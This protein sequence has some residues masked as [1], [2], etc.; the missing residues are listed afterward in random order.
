MGRK[1]SK[2]TNK[3]VCKGLINVHGDGLDSTIYLIP[4]RGE[5]CP[6]EGS[7]SVVVAVDS[8]FV[9]LDVSGFFEF[10]PCF[11]MQYFA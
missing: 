2:Q 9:T 3:M 10:V 4:A 5:G 6:F 7:G 11:V 1:E 8:L